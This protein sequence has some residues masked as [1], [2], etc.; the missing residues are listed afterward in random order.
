MALGLGKRMLEAFRVEH[1][2]LRRE[3]NVAEIM[4]FLRRYDLNFDAD[5]EGTLALRDQEGMLVGTGSARGEVL[6]TS[7]WMSPAREWG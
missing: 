4:D 6:P 1:V 2:N 5:V 7:Q 3:R